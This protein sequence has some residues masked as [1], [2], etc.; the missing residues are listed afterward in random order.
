MQTTCHYCKHHTK[1][2]GMLIPE[3]TPCCEHW[4]AAPVP[5]RYIKKLYADFLHDALGAISHAYQDDM[6]TNA[7]KYLVDMGERM[8]NALEFIA[9]KDIGVLFDDYNAQKAEYWYKTTPNKRHYYE[10]KRE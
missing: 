9:T 8:E 5:V 3:L 1:C 10:K 7:T 2:S 6:R 4:E